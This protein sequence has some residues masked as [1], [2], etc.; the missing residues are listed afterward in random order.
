[1]FNQDNDP[2]RPRPPSDSRGFFMLPQAPM[3]SGYYVYG[4]LYQRPAK[5]AYQYAH[6]LMMTAILNVG[7]EWQAMDTRRFGVG[8]ISLPGGIKTPDHG[9]HKS[10]LNVDIRP[11]RKDGREEP[12]K[13]S[14]PEYDQVATYALINLF[15]IFAQVQRVIFND[16]GIPFLVRAERHDDHFHLDL[17]G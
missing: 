10:G 5:G 4:N 11:L 13:W 17:R 6:P 12:V 1:M 8:D 9:G 15:H 16:P 2:R 3:D 14:D 7:L